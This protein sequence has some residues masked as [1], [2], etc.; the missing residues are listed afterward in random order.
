LDIAKLIRAATE[1][2]SPQILKKAVK[3]VNGGSASIPSLFSDKDDVQ[4]KVKILVQ[5][6]MELHLATIDELTASDNF[7]KE[8]HLNNSAVAPLKAV[9]KA[10]RRSANNPAEAERLLRNAS[11]RLTEI[12]EVLQGQV[13]LYINEIRK[14]DG[15][16]R[17]EFFLKSWISLK[18]V[19]TNVRCAKTAMKA[20]LEAVELQLTI[21]TQ[22]GIDA[23]TDVEAFQE[24]THN[25]LTGDNCR[26][27]HAYDENNKDEFWLTLP[28]QMT[29]A[30]KRY[31][32]IQLLMEESRHA[33]S[34]ETDWD[35][36]E[37][38]F[39]DID[40]N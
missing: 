17:L 10:F 15:M 11:D 7:L 26:L 39:D 38:D 29:E 2:V 37:I 27:M 32:A 18:T 9:K 4:E 8:L 22:L 21:F 13:T 5:F 19:D 20:V 3:S 28:S 12:I 36:S 14:H 33:E 30:L 35:I 25:I 6:L 40:Y 34:S 24:Y 23:S 16:S 31:D 1:K